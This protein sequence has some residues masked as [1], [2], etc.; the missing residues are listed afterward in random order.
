MEDSKTIKDKIIEMFKSGKREIVG[1]FQGKIISICGDLIESIIIDCIEFKGLFFIEGEIFPSPKNGDIIIFHE[2]KF[3]Y[4]IKENYKLKVIISKFSKP[5]NIIIQEEKNIKQSLDFSVNNIS[6]ELKKLLK[7]NYELQTGLFLLKSQLNGVELNL[8]SLSKYKE[9]KNFKFDKNNLKNMNINENDIILFINYNETEKRDIKLNYLSK[10]E[11][12]DDINLYKYLDRNE[13]NDKCFYG[14]IIEINYL[15]EKQMNVLFIDKDNNLKPLNIKDASK[16]V[17]FELFKL[18]FIINCEI[19]KNQIIINNDSKIYL[20]SQDIYFQT[21]DINNNSVIEFYFPDFESNNFYDIVEINCQEQKIN[22]NNLYFIFQ[23][24]YKDCFDFFPIDIFLISTKYKKRKK[25]KFII[26]HGI[27]NKI[28]CFINYSGNECFFYEF[29]YYSFMPYAFPSSFYIEVNNKKYCL[30][31]YDSFDCTTRRRFNLLNVPKNKNCYTPKLKDSNSFQICRIKYNNDNKFSDFGVFNLEEIK[32]S[33]SVDNLQFHNYFDIFGEVLDYL[34]ENKDKDSNNL[35]KYCKD[36]LDSEPNIRKNKGFFL[37][38][39]GLEK[40]LNLCEFKVRIGIIL[41]FYLPEYHHSLLDY[42]HFF[43]E[44]KNLYEKT[45]MYGLNY[46]DKLNI[47]YY[48]IE[49]FPDRNFKIIFVDELKENSPYKLALENNLKEIKYLTETSYLYICYLQLDGFIIKN[50]LSKNKKSHLFSMESRFILQRHLE[51][52]YKKYFI[53]I[54]TD[55]NYLAKYDENFGVTLI[56]ENYLFPEYEFNV[57]KDKIDSK[58]KN[59]AVPISSGFRHENNGH[60]K[61]DMKNIEEDSPELICKKEGP[62]MI[63]DNNNKNKGESG[64]FIESF[65]G[66]EEEVKNIHFSR[67]LGDTLNYEYYV[68]EN[69]EELKTEIKNLEYLKKEFPSVENLVYSKL[70]INKKKK[71]EEKKK[72][73]KK[74]EEIKNFKHK[75]R[76]LSSCSLDPYR[77]ECY[78][79]SLQ[80]KSSNNIK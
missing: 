15:S 33:H 65:I 66:T 32:Y 8:E 24:Y 12:L 17:K 23:T 31:K 50:Y 60:S 79:K 11:I 47:L 41:C 39:E 36:I 52:Q 21:I 14:K 26:V 10:I 37:A 58:S 45:E 70:Q 59:L 2:M 27:L 63:Q 16:N 74:E 75:K 3:E 44:L 73:I 54:N 64:L 35:I 28:N 61:K 53:V 55:E 34:L 42:Y 22:K 72:N 77:L 43:T 69:F 29:Y 80:K 76:K 78:I 68:K 6:K 57:V 30:N 19:E 48:F 71:N 7:I 67:H 13:I 1:D 25:F 51:Q 18:C 5:N 62:K 56:N 9:G 46:Y 40:D 38:M 4:K 20:S 49:N